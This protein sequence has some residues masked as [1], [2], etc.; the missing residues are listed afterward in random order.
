MDSNSVKEYNWG[1][2]DCPTGR[3]QAE[4]N[5]TFIATL[6]HAF[7]EY[8]K[9]TEKSN[10]HFSLKLNSDLTPRLMDLNPFT[11]F[12]DLAKFTFEQTD[13]VDGCQLFDGDGLFAVINTTIY[14]EETI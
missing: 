5:K 3:W 1:V 2:A 11:H 6:M 8:V 9:N 12:N 10:V 7:N 4:I 13:D 14:S